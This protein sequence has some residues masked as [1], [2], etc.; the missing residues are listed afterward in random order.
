MAPYNIHYKNWHK[1]FGT[2][3]PSPGSM[4]WLKR[5]CNLLRSLMLRPQQGTHTVVC[6]KFIFH[7]PSKQPHY[8]P[9]WMYLLKGSENPHNRASMLIWA[10]IMADWYYAF[11]LFGIVGIDWYPFESTQHCHSCHKSL[12]SCICVVT[13]VLLASYLAIIERQYQ[14]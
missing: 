1:N 2:C 14:Y 8:K 6:N 7:V 10:N 13:P 12:V 3:C 9:I 5:H 4:V 11:S